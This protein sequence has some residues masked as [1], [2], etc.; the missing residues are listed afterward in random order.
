MTDTSRKRGRFG[1]RKKSSADAEGR[2]TLTEHLREL[3]RRMFVAAL[4][5]VVGA[6]VGWVFYDQISTPS[7]AR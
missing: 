3:R 1:R 5:I 7:T 2:M 6:I 4:A